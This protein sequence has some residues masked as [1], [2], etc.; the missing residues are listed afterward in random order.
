MRG[1]I[2]NRTNLITYL[3]FAIL[4]IFSPVLWGWPQDN[5]QPNVNQLDQQRSAIAKA[6]LD[7]RTAIKAILDK[8]K[9]ELLDIPG[10]RDVMI[11][12]DEEK[13]VFNVF[14]DQGVARNRI[15]KNIEGVPVMA[16]VSIYSPPSGID[17]GY[18][19]AKGILKK[20]KKELFDIPGVEDIYILVRR[21]GGFAYKLIVNQSIDQARI[22]SAIEGIPV[23]FSFRKAPLEAEFPKADSDGK[24]APWYRRVWQ[25]IYPESED[26]HFKKLIGIQ[27]RHQAELFRNP[28]VYAVGIGKK[29]GKLGLH[30]YAQ[31]SELEYLP[32]Q[33]EGV[34]VVSFASEGFQKYQ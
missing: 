9:A 28:D 23:R 19:Q 33:I 10:I 3:H 16:T 15:P 14:T 24:D 17:K 6:M 8:H 34:V 18:E 25:T 1:L 4:L 29:D 13:F 11:L 31:K 26:E 21:G 22:P 5:A 7:K 32:T 20:H 12:R 27:A 30:V 2:I